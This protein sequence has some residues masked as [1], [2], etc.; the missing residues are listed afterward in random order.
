MFE[1]DTVVECV[2][3]ICKKLNGRYS[4]SEEEVDRLIERF[5]IRKGGLKSIEDF[6]IAVKKAIFDEPVTL[7]CFFPDKREKD[8]IT[9]YAVHGFK[10]DKKAVLNAIKAK[11]LLDAYYISKRIFSE[12]FGVEAIEEKPYLIFEREK[13]KYKIFI[14]EVEEL[15]EDL[16]YHLKYNKKFLYVVALLTEKTPLPFIR[17]FKLYSEKIRSK[18][19]VWVVD[20]DREYVNPF[21]GYPPEK[22]LIEKFK[23]PELAVK[24]SSLWRVNIKEID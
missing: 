12:F 8:G 23:N 17:F 5:F 15:E 6:K 4:T 10:I 2:K 13:Y 24:V 3:W 1:L 20:I 14:S 7:S 19:L 21:I 22:E 9:Y 18:M 16:E 11:R